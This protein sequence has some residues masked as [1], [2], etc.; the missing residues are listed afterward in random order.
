MGLCG[1]AAVTKKF[2]CDDGITI[3]NFKFIPDCPTVCGVHHIHRDS[4]SETHGNIRSTAVA[5]QPRYSFSVTTNR[6][7]DTEGVRTRRANRSHVCR[8]QSPPLSKLTAQH[9][10]TADHRRGLKPGR[11]A[12]RTTARPPPADNPDQWP[13]STPNNRSQPLFHTSQLQPRSNTTPLRVNTPGSGLPATV[14]HD[15]DDGRPA[16]CRSTR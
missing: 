11:P 3:A 13:T 10:L 16:D 7:A 15:R 12:A 5:G 4:S 2:V 9:I 6:K 1:Q 8:M 14:S